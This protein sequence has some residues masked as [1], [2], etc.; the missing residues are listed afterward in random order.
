MNKYLLST[1]YAPNVLH[2]EKTKMN[3]TQ[4]LLSM[5]SKLFQSSDFFIQKIV[6]SSQVQWNI[7][8]IPQFRSLREDRILSSRPV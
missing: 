4:F 1:C 3:E 8:V 6:Y 2:T 5:S 7:P